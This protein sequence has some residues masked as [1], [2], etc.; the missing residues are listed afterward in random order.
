[1]G[2]N[3]YGIF[4]KRMGTLLSLF[5]ITG[6]LLMPA[7]VT[8]QNGNLERKALPDRDIISDLFQGVEINRDVSRSVV[9]N[10]MVS[11]RIQ[12]AAVLDG[13]QEIADQ[14]GLELIYNAVGIESIDHRLDLDLEHVTVNSAL[15]EVL[16][17]TGFRFAVSSHGQLVIMNMNESEELYEQYEIVQETV[18]GRVV[19][20]QTGESLPG[21]NLAIQGTTTGTT[22]N[23]DGNFELTVPNLQETLIVSYI[24]YSR[25]EVQI[26]GRTEI[27]IELIPEII[28]GDELV[29]IG[30]GTQ[31][32]SDITSA[33]TPVSSE[34]ISRRSARNL[35]SSLQ[36]MAPGVTV[37]DLGGEPGA[38]NTNIRIRGVTT[39]GN[40][41]PLFIV[42]GVE[43]SFN[44]IN[45][46]DIESITI[47]E[48]ATSTAI[49]GSRAAN[50]VVVI[51]T[52]RGS[53]NEIHINF[54]GR[55]DFQ[56]LTIVPEHLDTEEH[57]RL[58]NLGFE[59]RGS[60]PRFS[61]EDI[62]NTI[63]GDN[64]LEY[65]EPNTWFD[66]VIQ[67]NAPMVRNSLSISGG[68][69][70]LRT[71]GSFSHFDQQGIYPN[72]DAQN[73]QLNL[74]NDI[75]I[76]D[77][78]SFRADLRLQ[79]NNRVSTNGI[80]GGIYHNMIHGSQFTVPRFPDGTYGLSPQ[81]HN[82]LAWTDPV[83]SGLNEQVSYNT[84]V[85]L[86]GSWNIIEGLIF[87]SR[88]AIDQNDFTR[89]RSWPT[90]EI[91]DYFNPNAVLRNRQVNE[92]DALKEESTQITWYN[93]L[94]YVF[95]LE[96][97]N[98]D[99]LGGFSQETY[100]FESFF[101]GGRNLYNN[102]L[103]NLGLSESDNRSISSSR[104]DW[105][106]QS[107]FS[108]VNYNYSN[109]Y[110]L[111][112]NMRYD[113]S[114][115][116]A[117]GDRY[118]F[119]PSASVG[120]R[121]SEE[122]FWQ[123]MSEVIDE[124]MLR[125]SWG[126]TGNQN[127]GLYTYFDNLSLQQNAYVFNDNPQLGIAQNQVTSEGLTWETTTQTNIGFDMS[128]YDGQLETSFDWYHKD[129]EGILLTLPIAGV[130]GLSPAATNAGSVKNVGWG[131]QITHRNYIDDLFYSISLNLSDVRNEITDLAG[132][133]PFF[134]GE[135]D[136]MV[137]MEG[138]PIDAIWG[139]ETNGFLTEEDFENGYPTFSSD[140]HPGDIKYVDRNGDGVI[141]AEDRTVIGSTL[142][143]YEFGANLD[144][145]WRNIDLNMQIQGVGSRDVALVGAFPE[146]GTWE[147]FTI[148]KAGDYWAPDNPDA[149]FPRPQKQTLKNQ[150]PSDWW[151]EDGAYIRLKN[152]QIG[153]SLPVSITSQLGI[154]NAR[155]FIGGT[156]LVTFSGLN[157]WGLDAEAPLGR[158]D[159][160]PPVKTYT[161]G[162]N[163][164]I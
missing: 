144:F 92:L 25:Q 107:L 44:D 124:F 55:V 153:Y 47:L 14:A 65:P 113:G 148:K 117:E 115:R 38:A 151:L 109:R 71:Y 149:R 154:Q 93:T 77:N 10:K 49:Y 67:R 4:L 112:F 51:E 126:E 103:R 7:T 20:A 85:N 110:Y 141:S 79:R 104:S 23:P 116:F 145:S 21:V 163:L 152:L 19:D 78:I 11:V 162:I 98:F 69:S 9:L 88:F 157:N 27:E 30:Y 74:N 54:N 34:V 161:I 52:K 41:N 32:R 159:Y 62:Q 80:G 94:G 53:E 132:T 120:W 12:D 86:R 46:N 48:D 130:V 143:R 89:E 142:P 6:M 100:E 164:N 135:R 137:R 2:T 13:L 26:D 131:A 43:Q 33:V 82:P 87:T 57:M 91:R 3:R 31:R 125:A 155:F 102:D 138:H 133:G 40:T 50:G 83:I 39:L 147:G 95:S 45:P 123:N 99:L 63:R 72:R 24:G 128:F 35:T 127:V 160:Y 121:I 96:N 73:Y 36:G 59:N 70:V 60:A 140:A 37:T 75:F 18:T 108:R 122:N 29:V 58:Q 16:Q 156:N 90:F 101:A 1:M 106:L 15:W 5:M 17:G 42:D 114:S 66:T 158:G 28:A 76:T 146:G 150:Q 134:A 118:T 111:E 97:H 136:W 56:N 8:G 64:L 139:Y 119:F 81:G 105:G 84:F 68:G 61:E 22:T 129:T